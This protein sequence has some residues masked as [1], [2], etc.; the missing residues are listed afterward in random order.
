MANLERMNCQGCGNVVEYYEGQGLFKCG[1]C[2][3]IYESLGEGGT[4]VRAIQISGSEPSAPAQQPPPV[5]PSAQSPW[6]TPPPL[7]QDFQD[8]QQPQP[9]YQQPQPGYQQPQPG[10]QQITA[11]ATRAPGSGKAAE[12]FTFRRFVTPV[13]IQ[14]IFW[15]GVLMCI[16]GGIVIMTGGGSDMYGYGGDEGW[17]VAVG[18]VLLILGPL[19]VR[20]W[21][22]LL[23]LIFR[24]FDELKQ[25]N[26]NAWY[27][28]YN[29]S[30]L[31][32]EEKDSN[33][34]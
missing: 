17:R 31:I 20:I 25:I 15:L 33:K 10:Y 3:S 1:S 21:C 24:I 4:G 26:Y 13:I 30:K 32:S 7:A 6:Q 11:P 27:T 34:A 9:G 22:E 28:N 16:I 5:E 14:I 18:L 2:G 8:Y 23:I 29:T 12:F 19:M